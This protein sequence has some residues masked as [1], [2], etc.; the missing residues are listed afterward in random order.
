MGIEEIVEWILLKLYVCGDSIAG[1]TST[2]GS[3]RFSPF[4]FF[5]SR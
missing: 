5:P 4:S 3:A 1:V 2:V